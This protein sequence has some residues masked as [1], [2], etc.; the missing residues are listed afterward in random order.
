MKP[1]QWVIVLFLIGL[2]TL[3]VNA[4]R[5][6]QRTNC[7]KT[8][9]KN[10]WFDDAHWYEVD[11]FESDGTKCASIERRDSWGA[12]GYAVFLGSIMINQDR[13]YSLVEAENVVE[14]RYCKL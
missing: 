3:S 7:H 8:T 1:P 2:T 11:Y 9:L 6:R 13:G 12:N 5:Y 4:Y 10:T 14:E